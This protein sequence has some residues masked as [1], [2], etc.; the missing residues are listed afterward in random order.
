MYDEIVEKDG[1]CSCR[2]L[3]SEC[4]ISTKSANKAINA[5]KSGTVPSASKRGHGKTG[6]GSLKKLKVQHHGYLY[7]LYL[8]NPSRPRISY[9]QKLRK[10]YGIRISKTFVTNWFQSF[11]NYKGSFR[12]ASK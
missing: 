11:G 8:R 4:C 6:V 3:A 2:Q 10:K 1:K 12:L 7:S 5:A 9:V